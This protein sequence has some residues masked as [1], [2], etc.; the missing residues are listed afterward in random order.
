[1][2]RRNEYCEYAQDNA[3]LSG[4]VVENRNE[5]EING[6]KFSVSYEYEKDLVWATTYVNGQQV[7][8]Y[9]DT[10]QTAYWSIQNHVN[11]LLNFRL[12]E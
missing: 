7:K 12:Q 6:E 3:G 10:E 8:T 2:V 1:M 9:G 4:D 11:T 5:F